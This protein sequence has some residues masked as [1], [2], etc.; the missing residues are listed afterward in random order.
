MGSEMCIRDR[1][2]LDRR[3]K[4]ERRLIAD[5]RLRV[6]ADHYRVTFTDKEWEAVQHGAI[7]E[8]FLS[9]LIANADADHVREM[10]SP[11]AKTVL[12]SSQQATIRQLKNRGY[13][14]ADIADVL[15]VS[16]STVRN[17]MAEEGL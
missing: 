2:D 9:E 3:A 1:D 15:G 4:L 14:N 8:N 5:A 10:A 11:R 6:G 7:T 17:Y 13:T 12:S 16:G